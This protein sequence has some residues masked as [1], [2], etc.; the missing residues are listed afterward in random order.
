MQYRA[1]VNIGNYPSGK[2]PGSRL[3]SP[4]MGL[5]MEIDTVQSKRVYLHSSRNGKAGTPA[6]RLARK[7]KVK[8]KVK[9]AGRRPATGIAPAGGKKPSWSGAVRTAAKRR[10]SG[11]AG[12]GK[13]QSKSRTTK[14]RP[15]PAGLSRR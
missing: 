1:A 11:S 8:V 12:S 13:I 6:S 9:V 10:A 15:R 14:F 3:I 7:V 5:S 2:N 4:A